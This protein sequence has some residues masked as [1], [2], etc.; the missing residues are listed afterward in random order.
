MTK[1]TARCALCA[2]P[3]EPSNARHVHC[4]RPCSQAARAGLDAPVRCADCNKC[5]ELGRSSRLD[6]TGRC[7]SCRK[8]DPTHGIGRYRM[9]CRCEVCKTASAAAARKF[10]EKYRSEHGVAYAT[11]WK[12]KVRDETG[13]WPNESGGWISRRKRG[14]IYERD[15]WKCHI[16]G[17]PVSREYDPHDPFSPTLD[18]LIPRAAG[19]PDEPN[20]LA[21]CHAICNARRGIR[22]L[23]SQEV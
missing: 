14:A 21:T 16:C 23:T 18:H 1:V 2:A 19:G 7:L 22:P 12:R 4:G 3:F 5:M 6:G 15:G 11:T 9:G 8:S 17:D 13:Y 10:G 20:N